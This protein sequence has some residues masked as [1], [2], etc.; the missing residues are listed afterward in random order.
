M[1]NIDRVVLA[2][3]V[4]RGVWVTYFALYTQYL[5][6]FSFRSRS[7]TFERHLGENTEMYMQE[8]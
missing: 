4:G 6:M 2:C 1:P 8:I 3:T 5:K 7:Y